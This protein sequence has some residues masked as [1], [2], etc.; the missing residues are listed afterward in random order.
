MKNK[1]RLGKAFFIV[2]F[3]L[4][5]FIMLLSLIIPGTVV[6]TKSA[7]VLAPPTQVMDSIKDLKSWEKWYPVI[8]AY[9]KDVT[10]LQYFT[11]KITWKYKNKPASIDVTEQQANAI[12]FVYKSEGN[13]DVDNIIT[14]FSISN[15]PNSSNVEWTA[16]TKLGYLPWNKFSGLFMEKFTG[17]GYEFG[18]QQ[19]NKLLQ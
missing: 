4:A 10:A 18:L 15:K 12:R 3:F 9:K 2:L 11:G 5:V 6:V 14:C 1:F 17:P 8:V 19:L 13:P 16:V 7:E